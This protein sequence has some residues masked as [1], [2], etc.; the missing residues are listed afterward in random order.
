METTEQ[1]EER[2]VQEA[3]ELIDDLEKAVLQLEES[4]MDRSLLEEVFRVMHSFKGTAKMFGFER[5]GEFT[6]YLENIFD[7][8]R[9]GNITLTDEIFEVTYNSVDHIRYL[10]NAEG[11]ETVRH[12]HFMDTVKRLNAQVVRTLNATN[13]K[14][15]ARLYL[16][17]FK[18]LIN[19]F[20]E[21]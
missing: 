21:G 17:H 5:I 14:P 2:F 13:R 12:E 7:D 18:P 3:M 16:I 4:R 19:F 8:L 15:A 20:R 9:R 1:L 11:Y 10:L 6:H